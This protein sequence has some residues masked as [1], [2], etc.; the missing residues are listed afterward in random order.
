[1][2]TTYKNILALDTA[3]DFQV[4]KDFF[5]ALNGAAELVGE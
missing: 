1:L 2:S 5:S 3:E 4:L